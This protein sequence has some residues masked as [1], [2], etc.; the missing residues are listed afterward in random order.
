MEQS[1]GICVAS[2]NHMQH[3]LG[4]ATAAHMAGK[5][6]EIF[7]TGDGVH[8]TQ[9]QRFGALM[10]LAR[11]GVCEVSYI[12]NG[13]KGKETF[14]LGDKDFVTQARNAEMVAECDRYVIV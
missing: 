9:D 14:G 1:L 6:V 5:Q 8:L 3:V 12:A 10:Q 2:R 4:L 7:F 13:Y 11:V